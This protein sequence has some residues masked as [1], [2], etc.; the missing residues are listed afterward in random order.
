LDLCAGVP[1]VT[2][3]D[4]QSARGKFSWLANVSRPDI[5]V[6][7]AALAR[8]TAISM[9]DDPV[10]ARRL[11]DRVLVAIR[12]APKIG[13]I[14]LPLALGPYRVVA[15][16]DASFAGNEDGTSQLGGIVLFMAAPPDAPN[17]D[18]EPAHLLSYFTRKSPRVCTSVFAAEVLAFSATF[19]LAFALVADLQ[20]MSL[21]VSL[22]MLTDS[23]SLFDTMVS[24]SATR[25]KRLMV[26]VAYLRQA[27]ARGDMQHLGLVRSAANIAD[28]LTKPLPGGALTSLLRTGEIHV[29][30]AQYL[31]R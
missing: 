12:N 18:P 7:V 29:D 26:D 15:F 8:V 14:F 4:I 30:V 21:N 6:L 22:T 10:H 17:A 25:E 11:V 20:A 5:S 24:H 27:Y 3:A 23:K 9:S 16:S 13:P 31:S 28:G 2:F 1:A 19:D